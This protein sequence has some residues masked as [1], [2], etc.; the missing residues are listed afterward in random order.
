MARVIVILALM[1]AI[2]AAMFAI[3]R[4]SAIAPGEAATEPSTTM[5][6]TAA[7]PEPTPEAAA[8]EE[9]E[10][11]KSAEP[12]TFETKV[13]SA[14]TSTQDVTAGPVAGAAP[15]FGT[16]GIDR[17]GRVS[18]TGTATPGDKISLLSAGKPV[19][20]TTAD[21]SGSWTLDFKPKKS[22]REL[23]LLVSAQSTDG[24]TIVGPQR[25]IIRPPES[26][27]GLPHIVLKAAAPATAPEAKTG[28]VVENVSPGENGLTMLRGKADPGATIKADINDKPAGETLVS[29]DGT[30]SLAASNASGKDADAVVLRLLDKDGAKLDETKVPYKVPSA[31]PKVVVAEAKPK[32]NFPSV[33]TSD[34]KQKPAPKPIEAPKDVAAL[35][36]P[37][38]APKPVE[39]PKDIAAPVEP[40]AETVAA[41][42][43]VEAPKEVA[44]P[45]EPKPA[46]D[47]APKP[48][49]AAK[50]VAALVEPA[51]AM[52]TTPKPVETAKDVAALIEPATSTDAAPIDKSTVVKVRRGDS[53]WRIARRHLGKGKKWNEFYAANKEKIDNPDLIYPGQV[54]IIPG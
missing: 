50:D 1:L 43:L 19:G 17:K 7:A 44:A 31:S 40:T 25:A 49:E 30:W 52:D 8:D 11:L 12:R 14:A 27:D 10:S 41:P 23:E 16:A 15:T 53:L 47:A 46:T 28:L 42:E 22:K 4:K 34:P 48:V 36:K 51:A 5:R 26:K 37:A 13:A 32:A 18:F 21:A 39:A 3:T 6:L 20:S 33:L 35:V 29:P 54:L 24:A 2:T 9:A 45:V 38:A